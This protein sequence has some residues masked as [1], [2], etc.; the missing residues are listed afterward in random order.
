MEF[1]QVLE[2]LEKSYHKLRGSISQVEDEIRQN[3]RQYQQSMQLVGQL[4][5]QSNQFK[6]KLSAIEERAKVEFEIL[7]EEVLKIPLES[8]Q[9]DPLALED[10]VSKL[11]TRLNNYGA[12]NYMAVEA[13]EEMRTRYDFIDTQRKD[14]VEARDT[15][16][17][18]LMEIETVATSLFMTAFVSVRTH[19]IS[20][21]RSLFDEDDTCDLVLTDPQN[22]LDAKIEIIAKPKG[23]K[24]LSINQ[25]SGG[26]KTLT[27]TA[28]LF[29]LYLLKPAPF[30]VFDEVDAP[31][32]DANIAKF[33]NIVR[34]FSANSQFIVVTHNKKTMETVNIMYGVTMV[35]SVSRV[36]PVDFRAYAP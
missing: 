20:V 36:V 3:N 29:A 32:D 31:L 26:E 24:P 25:L 18:T 14:L 1:Q 19:F 8:I 17:K 35:Q 23:K 13:Y 28:I 27:A 15:L 7:L 33:N 10:T 21:F 2:R 5:S 22:P 9:S 16:M 11:R 30:C 34:D 12:V 4:E 6:L